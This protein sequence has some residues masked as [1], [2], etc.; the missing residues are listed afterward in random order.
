MEG[1]FWNPE[2]WEGW[3]TS[4]SG[5]WIYCPC[6]GSRVSHIQKSRNVLHVSWPTTI[7]WS[8]GILSSRGR[9]HFHGG[10]GAVRPATMPWTPPI[11]PPWWI[12]TSWRKGPDPAALLQVCEQLSAACVG[13]RSPLYQQRGFYDH[14]EYP[15]VFDPPVYG[16]EGTPAGF[17]YID[18]MKKSP[19]VH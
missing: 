5:G 6:S 4:R 11:N 7:C 19:A 18:I 10:C 17:G 15:F 13:E 14:G 12:G 3:E 1:V 16:K 8:S 9:W 2:S